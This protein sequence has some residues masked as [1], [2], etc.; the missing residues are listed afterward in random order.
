MKVLHLT[1]YDTIYREWNDKR[2]VAIMDQR[3]LQCQFLPLRSGGNYSTDSV[4]HKQ[5]TFVAE[6]VSLCFRLDSSV[7]GGADSE[8]WGLIAF[9]PL[10]QS[11][12]CTQASFSSETS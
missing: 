8:P 4:S 11:Q 10:R 5:C 2:D 12:R 7:T 6:E 9:T 1:M 3:I